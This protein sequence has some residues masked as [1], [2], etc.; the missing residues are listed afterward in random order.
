LRSARPGATVAAMCAPC[1]IQWWRALGRAAS[2]RDF[3]KGALALPLVAAGCATTSAASQASGRALLDDV[4]SIDVHTHPAL[5][6]TYSRTTIDEHARAIESGKLGGAFLA[7]VGDGAALSTRNGTPYAA[8]QPAPGV[9]FA[10]AWRQLDVLDGH[11]RTLGMR[12]ILRGPDLAAATAA[13]GRVAIMSVEGADFLEGRL[14]HVQRAYDRGVRSIQLVHYRINELGDIQTEPPVHNGLTPFGR[15]V[16]REMN[17]LGML[18]D[19]AHAPFPVVKGAVET[20]TRP[21]LVSHT[22]IED[23]TGY[24]RFVSREHARLVAGAGGVLGAWPISIRPA[25]FSTFIDHIKRMVDAVGVEHVAIG[26]DIAGVN[27]RSALFTDWAEWP[28]IPS[29]LLDRGF[30]RQDVAR[31][32]GGNVQRLLETTLG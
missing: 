26:T 27:P 6:Q 21:T 17:R 10:S 14:E 32:M 3:V 8:R 31:I 25:G 4:I 12:R 2:R 7:A 5:F 29:A 9:L 30:A 24:A 1:C 16:V 15:D 18:I 22:N 28:S 13:R 20:S 23:Y 19:L 11:A